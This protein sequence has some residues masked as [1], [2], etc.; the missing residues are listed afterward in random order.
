MTRND[1]HRRYIEATG[2]NLSLLL[3][4]KK[5]K[6]F[7]FRRQ[8]NDKPSIVLYRVAQAP[9]SNVMMPEKFVASHVVS[10]ACNELSMLHDT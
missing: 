5:R 10:Q 3:A 4:S 8:F 6:D 2:Q 7:P 9:V 1:L